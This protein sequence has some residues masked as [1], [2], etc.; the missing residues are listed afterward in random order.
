MRARHF[1]NFES[2]IAEARNRFN[3][4]VARLNTLVESF[5]AK[6]IAKTFGFARQDY[7]DLELATRDAMPDVEISTSGGQTHG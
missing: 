1:L 6:I 5:P 2:E 3:R 7:L 4:N